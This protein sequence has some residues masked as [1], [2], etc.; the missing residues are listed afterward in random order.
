M[1]G[2]WE[3]NKDYLSK[4]SRMGNIDHQTDREILMSQK[5]PW[6]TLNKKFFERVCV[7]ARKRER[8]REREREVEE[9]K[10]LLCKKNHLL[11]YFRK[12][13]FS[14]L[15]TEMKGCKHI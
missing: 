3:R 9:R 8:E 15:L 10:I 4:L 7:C 11:C 12:K 6:G 13:Q 5:L 14:L 1:I 2:Q